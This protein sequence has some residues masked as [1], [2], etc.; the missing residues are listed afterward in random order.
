MEAKTVLLRLAICLIGLIC[1]GLCI[2][3]LPWMAEQTVELFPEVSYLKYPVLLGIYATTVPFYY[4]LYQGLKLL[5]LIDAYNAFSE[6]AIRSL[7]RIKFSALIIAFLY[8][9]GEWFL[10]SQNAMP[11]GLMLLGVAIIS[12]A[13]IIA[14]FAALLQE[15]L[16][17]ALKI[18][19]ENDLTI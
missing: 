11:P 10:I 2:F 3:W 6:T 16:S 8:V 13:V 15:L 7:K 4:A 5:G 9:G 1:L 19:K 12:A 18:Q 17:Q 14:L